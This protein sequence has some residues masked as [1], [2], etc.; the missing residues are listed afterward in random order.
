LGR[1]FDFWIKLVYIAGMNWITLTINAR[2]VSVAFDENS[3]HVYNAFP[4]KD[5]LK[6][7][8]YRW[9][10]GDKCWY[11]EPS[12]VVGEMAVLKNNLRPV[13]SRPPETSPAKEVG[14]SLL[15]RFPASYSVAELRNHIDQLI[16]S[17]LPGQIWVRGVIASEIKHY[18]WGSYFD[19]RDEDEA[20]NMHFSVEVRKRTLEEIQAKMQQAGAADFLE[21]ELPVF[22]LVSVGLSLKYTINVRLSVADILP[23]YTQSK[24]RSQLEVTL[25]KL[26]EEGILEYQKQLTLPRL[27][28]HIGLVTSAQGASIKDILAGL[29]PYEKKYHFFFVDARMEGGSAVDSIIRSID[30]LEKGGD[31]PLDAIVVARGGGSEQSLSVFNDY[32]LCRRICRAKIPILTAIGHEKDLSAAE[33]CSHFTPT[34]ST[35]SGV[36][37]FLQER[38]VKLQEQLSDSVSRLIHHF[39]QVHRGEMV[40]LRGFLKSIPA[41][42]RQLIRFRQRGFLALTRQFEQSVF[43]TVRDRER[44]VDE[45]TTQI[46]RNSLHIMM[47]ARTQMQGLML[48]VFSR[49]GI[50]S[51]REGQQVRKTILKMDFIKRR[52]ENKK[53]RL[54]V[55]Q[56]AVTVFSL[57]AKARRDAERTLTARTDL[58]RANHPDLILKKGFTMTLDEHHRVIKTLAAFRQFK[59]ADLKF[60]DG[61]ARI[62]GKEE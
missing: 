31:V 47:N 35:P 24:L 21:K 5:D 3:I 26:K 28:T 16:R 61:I 62:T 37:K 10:P 55:G 20:L 32:R 40:R 19:L 7:R 43:F 59:E 33:L 18:T 30:Y 51:R 44:Q 41:Q 57:A 52:R 23:E 1:G 50:L 15:D 11:I 14:D 25:E 27:L 38:Y 22:F 17:G 4:I 53:N 54:A 58:V 60:Y 49:A 36:G 6:L 29:H 12:D 42:G 2:E 9:N 46:I 8:G 34:P 39:S 48:S 13:S 45:K 56:A